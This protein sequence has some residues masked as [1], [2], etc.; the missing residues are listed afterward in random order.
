[1]IKKNAILHASKQK[2]Q[3]KPVDLPEDVNTYTLMIYDTL[4]PALQYPSGLAALNKAP[5]G[6]AHKSVG[7]S[8]VV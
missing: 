4:S 3:K 8:S 1:M 5:G 2:K 6:K 7:N